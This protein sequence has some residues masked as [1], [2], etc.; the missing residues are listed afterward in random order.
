MSKRDIILNAVR[1]EFCVVIIC[2][3]RCPFHD[4]VC[5]KYLGYKTNL[6]T[7]DKELKEFAIKLCIDFYGESVLFDT[8]L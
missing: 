7:W 5:Y 6:D 4:T 1:G 3:P 2:N 8:L